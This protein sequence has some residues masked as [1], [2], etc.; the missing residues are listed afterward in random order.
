M[1]L[2]Q[3]CLIVTPWKSHYFL[4]WSLKNMCSII[5]AEL[6]SVAYAV[7]VALKQVLLDRLNKSGVYV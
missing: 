7:L 2:V 6:F 5:C 4:I 1:C 3:H